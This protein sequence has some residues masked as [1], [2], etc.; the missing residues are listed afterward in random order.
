VHAKSSRAIP[1][2]PG[3]YPGN[4]EIVR[5]VDL[6]WAKYH[7]HLMEFDDIDTDGFSEILAVDTGGLNQSFLISGGDGSII[8]QNSFTYTGEGGFSLSKLGDLDGDGRSDFAITSRYDS[9][10]F[11]DGGSISFHSG[12]DGSVLFQLFG[13]EPEAFLG[14]WQSVGDMGDYDGDGFDDV[15]YAVPGV[16]ISGYSNAGKVVVASGIDGATLF[17]IRGAQAESWL[18]KTGVKNLGDYDDDGFDDLLA[19]SEDPVLGWLNMDL[20]S[21]AT[22]AIIHSWEAVAELG[23]FVYPA[24][25]QDMSGDGKL[26]VL[27]GAPWAFGD[28]GF[29][30]AWTTEQRTPLFW[31]RGVGLGSYFGSNIIGTFDFNGD[32][33]PESL[34]RSICEKLVDYS[35]STYK[36]SHEI[37]MLDGLT[38]LPIKSWVTASGSFFGW[39][40]AIF[41]SNDIDDDGDLEL[42]TTHKQNDGYQIVWLSF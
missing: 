4:L 41:V 36:T 34:E 33:I 11:Q 12:A 13:Q 16:T 20:Y 2:Y 25:S 23:H 19:F 39:G 21:G 28:V 6:P 17:E 1:A 22:G 26:D 10:G 18:G 15:Y 27:L 8:W 14:A 32:N 7:P 9:T 30:S 38:G 5:T 24:V 29:A 3:D 35:P 40:N 31:T 37:Q 42:V